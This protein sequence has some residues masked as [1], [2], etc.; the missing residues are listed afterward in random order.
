MNPY[1][2]LGVERNA[3][4]ETIKTAYRKLARKWHPDLFHTDEEIRIAEE[5]MKELNA[6]WEL[7]GTPEKRASFDTSNPVHCILESENAVKLFSSMTE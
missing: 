6:A 1:E 4:E 3:K 2:V 5:K 7:I